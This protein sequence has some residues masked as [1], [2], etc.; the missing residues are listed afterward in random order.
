ML[1]MKYRLGVQPIKSHR[2]HNPLVRDGFMDLLPK[3]T[4]L[5]LDNVADALFSSTNPYDKFNGAWDYHCIRPPYDL[6]WCEYNFPE[7][8]RS[9]IE[10]DPEVAKDTANTTKQQTQFGVLIRSED[11]P[12]G[13]TRVEVAM[14]VSMAGSVLLLS[15]GL[16]LF[17]DNN[18][19][20]PDSNNCLAKWTKTTLPG[21]KIAAC[22]CLSPIWFALAL[23]NTSNVTDTTDVT[24]LESP[25]AKWLRRQKQPQIKYRILE[26]EQTRKVLRDTGRSDEVGF[27]KALHF[28]RGH[29]ATYTAD[30]PLFGNIVGT[31]WKPAHVRGDI[32]QGAV[33]KDYSVSPPVK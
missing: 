15:G 26:I 11:L 9:S 22:Y 17:L 14:A 19:R 7:S 33:V 18:G 13:G 12:D 27:A 28:V 5:I 16:E 23:C 25:P 3:S 24:E 1:R 2:D 29:F 8:Y 31:V 21:T 20:C 32:K 10:R 4:S 6:M 30:K